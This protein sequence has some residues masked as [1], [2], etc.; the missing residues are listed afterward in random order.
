MTDAP[1]STEIVRNPRASEWV[2]SLGVV[3]HKAM[4]VLVGCV[5][6]LWIIKA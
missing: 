4:E 5:L 1:R 3:G 6:G 2:T